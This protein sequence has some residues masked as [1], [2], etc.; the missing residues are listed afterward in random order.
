MLKSIKTILFATNLEQNS[1]P[2]FEAAVSLA[3]TY[4][5]KI[6]LLHVL[7]K[8]PGYIE[9]RLAG[10]F[11]EAQWKEMLQAHETKVRQKLIGKRSSSELIRQTLEHFCSQA[12]IDDA[13]CGYE[14]REVVVTESG[15]IAERI[16]ENVITHQCDVIVLGGHEGLFTKQSIGPTVRSVLKKSKIPVLVVPFV[17]GEAP[18]L[19][20]SPG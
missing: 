8:M 4:R 13:S 1:V 9:G 15:D 17:K 2:A 20:I 7:E 3:L 5:A 10:L 16:V 18:S 19:P 12:G 11:G 14:S 6:V